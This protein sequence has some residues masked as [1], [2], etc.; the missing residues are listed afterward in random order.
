MNSPEAR[1]SGTR[2]ILL[3]FAVVLILLI[4]LVAAAPMLVSGPGR[5]L[6][7][8]RVNTALDGHIELDSLA[9]GWRGPQRISGLRLFDPAGERVLGI[10]SIEI[11][12]GLLALVRRPH[13]RGEIR[14]GDV[15][16]DFVLEDD[17]GSNLARAAGP[18]GPA[19]SEPPEPA[20]FAA[21]RGMDCRIR[22][23]QA[24]F[25]L[26]APGMEPIRISA[27]SADVRLDGLEA[28]ELTADAA[29]T[30]GSTRG[31]LALRATA[32]GLF[33][34]QARLAPE[35]GEFDFE[36]DL[37]D[38]P[39]DMADRLAGLDGRLRAL[40]GATANQRL[41][42]QWSG[43]GGRF[44]LD[45]E[46]SGN[47]SAG[48][49]FE[50]R[51]G[52]AA[53]RR[54]AAIALTVTPEAWPV[55]APAGASL[56]QPFLIEAR[57]EQLAFDPAE[58]I[59]AVDARL[60]VGDIELQADDPRV[61]RLALR[62]TGL[63][64]TSEDLRAG[65]EVGLETTAEQGGRSGRAQVGGRLDG[66][67]ADDLSPVPDGLRVDLDGTVSELPLAVLDQ[68][69][70]LDGLLTGALGPRL[71][72]EFRFAGAP[73]QGRGEFNLIG[74]SEHLR[75]GISGTL[76]DDGLSLDTGRVG[77]QLQPAVVAR[78][79]DALSL[80][81]A[82][83][84]DAQ[85]REFVVPR[86]ADALAW[87]EARV[88]V[89]VALE[90]TRARVPEVES[91]LEM[92]GTLNAVSARLADGLAVEFDGRVG[93]GRNAGRMRAS[94]SLDGEMALRESVRIELSDFPVAMVDGLAGQAG[95]LVALLGDV[96]TAGVDVQP[97]ADGAFTADLRMDSDRA[98]T[99]LNARYESGRVTVERGAE[100]ELELTPAAVAAF[101]E[102]DAA[103]TLVRTARVG[104]RFDR[105][106][107]VLEGGFDTNALDVVVDARMPELV[108]QRSDGQ[109][110]SFSDL[111]VLA[112]GQP[113][114]RLLDLR[115]NGNLAGG[116]F[117]SETALTGLGGPGD[118]TMQTDTRFEDVPGELV[119]AL[120]GL[121]PAL[122]PALGPAVRARVSGQLP[123]DL[124]VSAEGSNTRV[125]A[126]ARIGAD[127]VLA[128]NRDAELTLNIT[129]PL[130]DGYLARMHP[131][132]NDVRSAEQPIRLML[133]ADGF[134]LPL[135]E[136]R[137]DAIRARGR[138]EIG[139]LNMNRGAI[140]LGLFGALQ[141]LGGNIGMGSTFQAR[142]TPLEFSVR[143]GEVETNDL[144]MQ[145]DNLM[146]G[147]QGRV[148]LPEQAEDM[149]W[150][151]ML[152]AVP[153]QTLRG[154]PRIAGNIAAD[155]ILT[156]SSSGPL[157]Q[158]SPDF[159]GMFA[160][161]V[162]QSAVERLAGDSEVGQVIGGLLGGALGG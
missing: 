71:N 156:T 133:L 105:L 48:F 91:M 111:Q 1:M 138:L 136:Y 82:A 81:S 157:D 17:G 42:G 41:E 65:L 152:F 28:L 161:L 11:D 140:T 113:L 39:V 160:G 67:L 134:H 30:Q 24:G 3:L 88:D 99:R 7:V 52:T 22:L 83:G 130:I 142:F 131:F 122:G 79:T 120:A 148:R 32:A 64:V 78:F 159:S 75:T 127:G 106:E 94:A 128:L 16:G 77:L 13:C 25:G 76:G 118:A 139:T 93:D 143:D 153:G 55:L 46:S 132:L 45:M 36:L 50:I 49:E 117:H 15:D 73:A 155:T 8:D 57:I 68:I 121:D 66:F 35:R 116:Q 40:V 14:V 27:L 110:V 158:I 102:E 51:D 9:V 23:E 92:S 19:P 101:Q 38:F 125:S 145:M 147:A 123:G 44:A 129:P 54:P 150:A 6:V 97:H 2:K 47:A 31:G 98:R 63:N 86:R 29:L 61:G 43:A 60:T 108:L 87:D 59:A 114:G 89:A 84:L 137:P 69:A 162:T 112:D 12:G 104:V 107:A 33:D 72:A 62:Q 124:Q 58:S 119:L 53:L 144:W 149:P 74:R 103:W 37:T 5:G 146:L 90:P 100:M 95:R 154:L 4:G 141:R 56:L 18:A 109:S 135:T 151:E 85:V 80:A 126:D 115:L 70:G 10:G 21:L 26:R 96:M 34:D 20:G